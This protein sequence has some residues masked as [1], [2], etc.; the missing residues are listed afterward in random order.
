[1]VVLL[2]ELTLLSREFVKVLVSSVFSYLFLNK[3]SSPPLFSTSLLSPS[4]HEARRMRRMP[5]KLGTD[6]L[7]L[8]DALTLKTLVV[9]SISLLKD[10]LQLLRHPL[11]LL[12]LQ[13]LAHQ[14]DTQ[15]TWYK[16]DGFYP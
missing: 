6:F 8:V 15:R 4:T 12:S 7:K 11:D 3:I 16:I 13:I 10:L 5:A 1:M 2:S 14:L 9:L